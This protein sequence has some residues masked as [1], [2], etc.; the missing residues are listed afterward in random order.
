MLP[1]Q[2]LIYRQFGIFLILVMTSSWLFAA[3]FFLPL[4]ATFGDLLRDRINSCHNDANDDGDDEKKE[5][6]GKSRK[7]HRR[8]QF[9]NRDNET[10]S[11]RHRVRDGDAAER[12]ADHDIR[13]RAAVNRISYDWWL[14]NALEPDS[15]KGNEEVSNS[16]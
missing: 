9:R 1:S 12:T 6:R 11:V 15:L 10:I 5:K 16:Y 4:C 13:M 7:E 3:F 2:V 8:N 14:E